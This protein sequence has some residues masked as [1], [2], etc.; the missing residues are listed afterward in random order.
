MRWPSADP[1]SALR[2]PLA[3]CVLLPPP[4]PPLSEWRGGVPKPQ[5]DFEASPWEIPPNWGLSKATVI[6]HFNYRCSTWPQVDS[7]PVT[8][9]EDK[10]GARALTSQ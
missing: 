10:P 2:P 5:G 3:L 7:G 4:A 1:V 6:I 9:P 8:Q